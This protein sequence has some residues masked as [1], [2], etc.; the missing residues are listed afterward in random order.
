MQM[1]VK[2]GLCQSKFTIR[3]PHAPSK[4]RRDMAT[5]KKKSRNP[6]GSPVMGTITKPE[7]SNG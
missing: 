2:E 4:S 5:A 3:N 6:D 1:Q 7:V